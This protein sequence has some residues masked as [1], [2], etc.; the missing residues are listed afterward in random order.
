MSFETLCRDVEKFSKCAYDANGGFFG[1]L[2]L[3][4]GWLYKRKKTKGIGMKDISGLKN[5]VVLVSDIIEAG[6]E[7]AKDGKIGLDDA[8][9]LV[10]LLPKIGPAIAGAG[11]IPAELE[12]L[13]SE[14]VV[15]LAAA[16]AGELSV[17]SEKA[18]QI[19]AASFKVLAA[20][21]E[22]KAAIAAPAVP[23]VTADA[24]A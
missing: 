10:K 11:D 6:V 4:G 19:I 18:K 22:L 7:V 1:L 24:G 9:V 15:E 23:S 12:D 3:V 8:A 21:V 16:V 13:S 14:E 2:F 20:L 17:E 5:V